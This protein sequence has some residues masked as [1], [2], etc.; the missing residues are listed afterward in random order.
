MGKRKNQPLHNLNQNIIL[1][2]DTER[3][4]EVDQ[5]FEKYFS[6]KKLITL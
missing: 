2:D 6:K 1:Q 4:M 5:L 3:V